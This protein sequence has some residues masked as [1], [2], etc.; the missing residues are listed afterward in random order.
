MWAYFVFNKGINMLNIFV[1]GGNP[2]DMDLTSKYIIVLK[3]VTNNA[4]I[5][6]IVRYFG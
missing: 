6:L 5:V 3:K 4:L 2:Y 1:L